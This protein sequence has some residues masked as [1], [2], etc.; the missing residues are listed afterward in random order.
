VQG[1]SRFTVDEVNDP[2]GPDHDA[3]IGT[4]RP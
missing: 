4:A 2:D 1:K 3:C